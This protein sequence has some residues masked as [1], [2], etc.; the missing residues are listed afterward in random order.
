MFLNDFCLKN[1][2]IYYC[3]EHNMKSIILC[4]KCEIFVHFVSFLCLLFI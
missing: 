4:L 3:F 2:F 1:L